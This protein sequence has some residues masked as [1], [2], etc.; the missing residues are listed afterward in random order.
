MCYQLLKLSITLLALLWGSQTAFGQSLEVGLSKY[1][2]GDMNGAE[3]ALTKAMSTSRLRGEKAK[4]A[5]LMGIVLYTKGDK[6]AAERN[7]RNALSLDPRTTVNPSETLDPTVLEFFA[8]IKADM[9]APTTQHK[10]ATALAPKTKNQKKTLLKI[11]SSVTKGQVNIDGILAG[12]VNELIN[13][14]PGKTQLEI[15]APGYESIKMTVN[16]IENQENVL[17]IKFE[18]TKPKKKPGL[19]SDSGSFAAVN[20]Y[21][22]APKTKKTTKIPRKNRAKQVDLFEEPENTRISKK[23]PERDLAREFEMDA[24]ASNYPQPSYSPPP[25]PSPTYQNP[26]GA[27]AYPNTYQAPVYN[28]PPPSPP[29]PVYSYQQPVAPPEYQAQPNYSPAPRG[30]PYGDTSKGIQGYSLLPLGI[31]QFNQSRYVVGLLFLTSEIGTG[32]MY[33]TT[34]VQNTGFAQNANQYLKDFCTPGPNEE[35]LPQAV[36]ECSTYQTASQNYIKK[37]KGEQ[38]MY[39][40]ATIGLAITGIVEAIIWDTSEHEPD[41]PPSPST[42]RKKRPKVRKYKGFSLNFTPQERL[43]KEERGSES[44]EVDSSP[45]EKASD[46]KLETF[47]FMT[48]LNWTWR[49]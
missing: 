3:K 37:R 14:E 29:P 10:N 25:P 20:P 47:P 11:V 6:S 19:K 40:I 31:G 48:A 22:P 9:A 4:I 15:S 45:S 39:L 32:Y 26:Y 2:K 12:S 41:P 17:S 27:P 38:Q 46:L 34:G 42:P 44:T 43:N 7:F 21:K 35:L 16:I 30:S 8:K 49:F 5:S 28:Y 1:K 23:R 13:T 24:A 36:E 18:K 33:Y